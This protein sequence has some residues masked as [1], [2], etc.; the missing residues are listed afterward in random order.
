MKNPPIYVVSGP[1]GSG[2]D[3]VIA[4]LKNNPDF[5]ILVTCTTRPIRK[6][7][8]NGRD[9]H[10]LSEKEFDY[11]I[12]NGNFLEWETV[13][14]NKYGS[15]KRDLDNL[16]KLNK[17]VIAKLDVKGAMNLKKI[18]PNVTTIF[19]M[20]PNISEVKKRLKIRSTEDPAAIAERIARYDLELGYKDKFDF[21]VINDDL[22]TARD[23]LRAI[24]DE[25]YKS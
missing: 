13:F 25:N 19:I 3:S 9:Y 6:G 5:S 10:F 12:E 14:E 7:E 22:K 16:L 1:S 23:D 18:Y 21:I 15:R 24:I 2:K 17:P 4:P 8:I 20:P 11:D